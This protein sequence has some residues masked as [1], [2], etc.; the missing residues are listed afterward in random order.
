MTSL[1]RQLPVY[2]WKVRAH[3]RRLG[4]FKPNTNVEE[5]TYLHCQGN[6]T[7]ILNMEGRFTPNHLG[8][9]DC[10]ASVFLS[11][12][13]MLPSLLL[14]R[15]VLEQRNGRANWF[16]ATTLVPSLNPKFCPL[17]YLPSNTN[18]NMIKT[19]SERR[20]L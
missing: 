4:G 19:G 5:K 11:Q 10:G 1:D 8:F 16:A 15:T 9:V 7:I 12:S 13:P 17:S 14:C 2:D 18:A 6:T 20:D 3:S